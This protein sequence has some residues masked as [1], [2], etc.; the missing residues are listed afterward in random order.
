[1]TKPPLIVFS[2]LDGTLLDHVDYSFASAQ[3]ALIRLKEAKIPLVLASS[4]TAAEVVPLR[5]EL[6]FEHVAAI[7]ENG[8]GILSA[9]AS[10]TMEHSTYAQVRAALDALP[11]DMRWHFTG[12]GDLGPEGI[13]EVTGL[14]LEQAQLAAERQ[15]SEPGQ[16]NGSAEQLVEFTDALAKEGVMAREGGRFLTLSLGGTKADQMQKIAATHGHPTT[17]ALGDAPN[18]VEMLE[19]ADVAVIIANPHRAP[20]PEQPGE[21]AGRIRRSRL[22][23]PRGWNEAVQEILNELGI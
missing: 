18:D 4:K 6:G 19:T 15:F 7:V 8:A 11:S 10:G 3:P 5:T 16:W 17:V 14:T 20:L 2:D 1:M 13:A 22:D 12:F 21:A 23:G 9:G